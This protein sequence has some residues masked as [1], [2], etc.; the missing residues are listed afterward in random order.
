MWGYSCQRTPSLTLWNL[1]KFPKILEHSMERLI[2]KFPEARAN[3]FSGALR[4][5]RIT[6]RSP[7]LG[8]NL[9]T[10]V[11]K[12]II[13]C[14]VALIKWE[15]LMSTERTGRKENLPD[16]PYN[17]AHNGP[18]FALVGGAF[19]W[20][21]LTD[22]PFERI[23]SGSARHLSILNFEFQS[24]N[25]RSWTELELKAFSVGC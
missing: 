17:E 9:G 13:I 12:S 18:N 15:N 16:D 21:F 14:R 7:Y 19:V 8:T 6:S 25:F 23:C 4:C 20:R 22:G 24:L 2:R 1:W 3:S 5:Q 11:W 10:Q